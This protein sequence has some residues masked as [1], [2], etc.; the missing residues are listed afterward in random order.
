MRRLQAIRPQR[1]KAAKRR[2]R[3]VGR[4]LQTRSGVLA[5]TDDRQAK[6][7][8]TLRKLRALGKHSDVFKLLWCLYRYAP[9]IERMK[10]PRP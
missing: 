1:E 7:Q 9:E 8:K 5:M 10:G 3:N 6:R 4:A 2:D